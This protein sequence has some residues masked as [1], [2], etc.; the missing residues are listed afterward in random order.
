[1]AGSVW[2][3]ALIQLANANVRKTDY[4]GRHCFRVADHP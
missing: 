1:M 4:V 2:L 3:Y